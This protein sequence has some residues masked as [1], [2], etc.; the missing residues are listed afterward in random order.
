MPIPVVTHQCSYGCCFRKFTPLDL[1]YAR[2]IHKF[3]GITVGKSSN[4]EPSNVYE[5]VVCDPDDRVFEGRW[6]GMLYTIVSRGNSLG[7]PDGRNSAVYFDAPIIGSSRLNRQ[8]LERLKYKTNSYDTLYERVKLREDFVTKLLRRRFHHSG[9]PDEI[10]RNL[11]RIET[12][13]ISSDQLGQR[14][15]L[16]SKTLDKKIKHIV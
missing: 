1:A 9:G 14:V 11:D 7:D 8:R 3:Q 6:P 13:L 2:S 16:Y 15:E 5:V 4:G 10:N 12:L